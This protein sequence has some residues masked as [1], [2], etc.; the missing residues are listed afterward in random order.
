MEARIRTALVVRDIFNRKL[1]PQ[2]QCSPSGHIGSY[3]SLP[4]TYKSDFQEHE[5]LEMT[6]ETQRIMT[7]IEESVHENPAMFIGLTGSNKHD[8]NIEIFHLCYRPP[9]SLLIR[10]YEPNDVF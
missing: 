3:S 2:I 5:V 1:K 4:P 9:P 6:R 7:G 10:E 8:D